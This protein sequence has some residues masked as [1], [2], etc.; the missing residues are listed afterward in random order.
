MSNVGAGEVLKAYL[1]KKNQI[2][3][4]DSMLKN[5]LV[6]DVAI[7]NELKPFRFRYLTQSE[8]TFQPLSNWLKGKFDKVIFSSETTLNPAKYDGILFE[9]KSILR[10]QRILPQTMH[11]MF[12]IN[13][14]APKILELE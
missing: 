8:M 6:E 14:K 3:T 7:S 13:K 1:V 11:G 4:V 9:D 2:T 10:V 12:L 5:T